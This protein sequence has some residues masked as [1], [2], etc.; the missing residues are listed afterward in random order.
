L[1]GCKRLYAPFKGTEEQAANRRLHSIA[2][3]PITSERMRDTKENLPQN[4][5]IGRKENM[6][7]RYLSTLLSLCIVLALLPTAAFAT[8]ATSN[9]KKINT[10]QDGMFTDVASSAW[11]AD[12]IKS[13]YELGLMNGTGDSL[14]APTGTVTLAQAVTMAARLHCI[15]YTGS[16]NF[17]PNG[18]AWYSVYVDYAKSA[19]ILTQNYTN[20]EVAATR[21]QFAS[22]FAHALP[23]SALE[24]I[25][26]VADNE[27]QGVRASHANAQEIYQLYRA[28][29][30]TGS[31]DS[32]AFRPSDSIQRAEAAAVV[33]R[34]AMPDQRVKFSEDASYT[35]QGDS[36]LDFTV[37]LT[38]GSSFTLSEQAGKVVLVNFWATWCGPCVREMPDI[39]KLYN[40]YASGDEV[41]IIFI[42]CGESAKTVQAFL[43]RQKYTVP[44][45]CDTSNAISNTYNV[46]AI[47][48][49]VIFG[50]DGVVTNDFTGSQNYNT[51]K[52]AID[53]ALEG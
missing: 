38:D 8:G 6:C 7:R 39:V 44:V 14:F 52:S 34:M 31:G 36:A 42:N 33:T 17:Q 24:A 46:N 15:Y 2:A 23:A 29:V 1:S 37:D 50:K 41:E 53:S 16:E 19:G 26:N 5:K 11:Y 20:Y 21:A 32:M 13:A 12:G 9:F 40:E 4:S 3:V 43:N 48:R 25:N 18:S 35:W 30:L 47:P 51:F 28:G 22:L 45:A 49:T 10:Y 27:I